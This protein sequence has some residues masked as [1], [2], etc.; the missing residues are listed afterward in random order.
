MFG[1]ANIKATAK[2]FEVAASTLRDRLE[3]GVIARGKIFTF[4]QEEQLLNYIQKQQTGS[5]ITK[6]MLKD[7]VNTYLQVS[8]N[9]IQLKSQANNIDWKVNDSWFYAFRKRHP[10]LVTRKA[11]LRETKRMRAAT[12]E[13][14]EGFYEKLKSVINENNLTLKQIHNV[15]ESFVDP[16]L[17]GK[18]LVL[19]GSKY[20]QEVKSLSKEHI[21]V[22]SCISANGEAMKHVLI[23]T[24]KNVPVD[25]KLPENILVTAT[26][27]GW[28]D[29]EVKRN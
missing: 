6:Q 25:L 4:E 21:T 5:P 18:V 1:T 17:T 28:I 29:N 3:K 23:M 14:I 15:D 7:L 24:G 8:L 20:Y 22:I 13:N 11:I 16:T 10:E 27:K 12:R 2:K 26:E 9:G 19:K